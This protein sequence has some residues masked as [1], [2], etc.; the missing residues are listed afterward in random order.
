M[1][2][3][4][5]I[6]VLSVLLALAANLAGC[7]EPATPAFQGWIEA[8]L[9]F[10]GPDEAGRVETLN[11]R[12]GDKIEAG[13]PLFG[14]DVDLQQADVMLNE[15]YVKNAQ[16]AFDR[17]QKLLKS[18]AGTEKTLEDAEVRAADIPGPAQFLEDPAHPPQDGEPGHRHRAAGLLPARR[19]G[20]GRPA[21]RRAAAARQPQGPL[22]CAGSGAAAARL[23]RCHQGQLRRLRR[24]TSPPAFPSS[25][26]P[27]S[28][29]RR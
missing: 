23:R 16:Q 10:V 13:A 8:N 2:A 3:P 6:A 28:S 7:N 21:H 19:D 12:E 17:A 20:P 5:R 15:A 24:P 18:A 22:L 14:V 9:I 26:V 1:T 11:V 29:R 25:R 4:N 27:P